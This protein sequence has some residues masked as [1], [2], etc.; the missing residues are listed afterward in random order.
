V[1]LWVIVAVGALGAATASAHPTGST[2]VDMAWCAAFGALVTLAASRSRRWPW[3]WLA[4]IAAAASLGAGAWVAALALVGLGAAFAAAFI[5]HRPRLVGALVGALS[6]QAL[7][8]LPALGFHGLP[9]LIA[10]VAVAPVL[11]SAYDRSN[12]P[13]RRRLRRVA[14]GLVLV[15]MVAGVGAGVA[16]LTAR[17]PLQVGVDASRA[18]LDQLRGGAAATATDQFHTASSS[19]GQASRRLTAPW[20][21]PGRLLPVV[22]QHL[23]ALTGV[24]QSGREL[25]DAAAVASS[26]ADYQQLRGDKGQI[27]LAV[28]ARMQGPVAGSA[29]ALD[30]A[31]RRVDA[32]SSPWLVGPV[33]RPLADFSRQ[34][35]RTLPQ[36]VL[37]RDGLAVAP[38]MLGSSGPRRYLVL[39]T[40]PAETR[41]LGGFVGAYGILTAENGKLT[42]TQSGPIGD[43]NA[44]PGADNRNLD[45]TSE[46]SVRYGRYHV[47]TFLQNLTAGPDLPEDAAV[48][49]QL[50]RQTTG[51]DID[52]VIVAD[53]YGLAALLKLT[54]PVEV[55]G[56]DQPLTADNAAQ[57]LLKDQYLQLTGVN[58]VNDDRRDKLRLA[59][60]ATFDALTA[61]SL[62][63]LREV[64]D[65]L[66]PA[67]HAGRLSFTAFDPA[68]QRFLDELGSTGRLAI[69]PGHDYLSVRTANAQANKI[70]SFLH[71]TIDYEAAV[72]P[73][74]GSVQATARVTLVNSA[75]SSG[76]PDYI[77]GN[78]RKQPKGTTSLYLSLY[79]PLAVT[80]ATVDGV[81]VGVEPQQELGSPVYSLLVTIA[82]GATVTV[83]FQLAGSV[84]VSDGYHLD[85]SPQPMANPDQS[86]VA[87]RSALGGAEVVAA[88]GLEVRDGQAQGSGTFDS[89]QSYVVRFA[90]THHN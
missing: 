61:R 85:L 73:V 22:G 77:I 6:V 49:R 43:L 36:A 17:G 33:A 70:D 48:A 72:A 32:I 53:P 37:A 21:W 14:L 23:R 26:T 31:R 27:D 68:E 74:G 45:P 90:R 83:E 39:F 9:S 29:D 1:A 64:G 24:S 3:F 47:P 75:P 7:L 4:G 89:S 44:A 30:A 19:F 56:L 42:F 11:W 40:T 88:D 78:E 52:G 15:V 65:S 8:R 12:R 10:A 80:G 20:S 34:I 51:Q 81:A 41:F 58:G 76:L 79:S 62:P 5:R 57:Y 13:M 71:R 67:M 69:V 63:S 82:P 66:G 50:Y 55:E 84:D 54:G 28:V 38:G 35:D 59:A 46:F 60:K 25:A 18:G 2:L 86:S 16:A 87:V